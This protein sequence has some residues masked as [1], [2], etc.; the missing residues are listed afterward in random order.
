ML[1][2]NRDTAP[3]MCSLANCTI[4][5]LYLY[6]CLKVRCLLLYNPWLFISFWIP[7]FWTAVYHI[8]YTKMKLIRNLN[9]NYVMWSSITSSDMYQFHLFPKQVGEWWCSRLRRCC[10]WIL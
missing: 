10:L 8:K 9:T 2:L 3:N 1:A 5:F 4:F 6:P 7:E